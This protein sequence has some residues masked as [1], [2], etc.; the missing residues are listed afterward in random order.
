MLCRHFNSC[1][2]DMETK[3]QEGQT[4]KL[5]ESGLKLGSVDFRAFP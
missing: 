2:T 4:N 3:A 5:V 1:F